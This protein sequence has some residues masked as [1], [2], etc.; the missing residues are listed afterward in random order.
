MAGGGMLV[1]MSRTE[2]LVTAKPAMAPTAADPSA[3]VF[4]TSILVSGVRCLLSYIVFPWALPLLGL[5]GGVG[6][7]LGIAI[8]T[9]AIGFNIA[10]I[11]R[12][13]MNDHRWKIPITVINV[14]VIILLCILIG[15]DIAEVAG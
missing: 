8:G 13:W 14:S 2:R 4:S 15:L 5:A 11:R 1:G 3:N 6:P 9:V 7:A 12:F 10:S